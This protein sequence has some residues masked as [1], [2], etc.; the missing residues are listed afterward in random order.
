MLRAYKTLILL[1]AKSQHTALPARKGTRSRR[2]HYTTLT[3]ASIILGR[4]GEHNHTQW[5]PGLLTLTPTHA[6]GSPW[7]RSHKPYWLPCEIAREHS[8]TKRLWPNRDVRTR[9]PVRAWR[10]G[11]LSHRAQLG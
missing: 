8:A 4:Q 10:E 7:Q 5:L 3:N 9:F 6:T 2:H 11:V 1:M